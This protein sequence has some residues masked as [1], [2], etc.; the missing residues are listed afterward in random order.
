[1]V[2]AGKWH[3]HNSNPML[4]NSRA[5][6]LNKH[7]AIQSCSHS[8]KAAPCGMLWDEVREI[9]F[10]TIYELESCFLKQDTLKFLHLLLF[11]ASSKLQ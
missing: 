5:T 1:M 6:V 9:F 3:S 10:K 8:T 7:Q 4:P 11:R 2:R